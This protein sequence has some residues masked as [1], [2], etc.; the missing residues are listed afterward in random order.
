MAKV[1]II[2][3]DRNVIYTVGVN[4]DGCEV[5]GVHNLARPT[6]DS[7]EQVAQAAF[8]NAKPG[9]PPAIMGSTLVRRETELYHVGT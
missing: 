4:E 1:E 2:S 7:A 9:M 6:I 5:Y 3:H 8:S